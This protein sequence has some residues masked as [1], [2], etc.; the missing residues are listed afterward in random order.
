MIA[1]ATS[2]AG[3]SILAAAVF[4]I[5]AMGMAR[6]PQ[7]VVTIKGADILAATG[8]GMVA[9]AQTEINSPLQTL[10]IKPEYAPANQMPTIVKEYITVNHYVPVNQN[11]TPSNNSSTSS[12]TTSNSNTNTNTVNPTATPTQAPQQQ[13]AAATPTPTPFFTLPTNPPAPTATPIVVV[14]T[15]APTQTPS[16]PPFHPSLSTHVDGDKYVASVS[17]DRELSLCVFFFYDSNNVP[18]GSKS[19]TGSGSSCSAEQSP[20][21]PVSRVSVRVAAKDGSKADL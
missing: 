7:P 2:L 16:A 17:A 6:Q 3:F 14:S 1:G 10:P 5:R 12:N 8:S 4:Q 13:T 9:G 21:S 15:P 18:L 20:A 19:S 11:T